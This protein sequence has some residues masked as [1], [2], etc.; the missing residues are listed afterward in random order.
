MV[1]VEAALAIPALLAVTMVLV[2]VV[3][4]ASTSL[5]LGDATRQAA[6]DIARGVPVAD[7]VGAARLRAPGAVVDAVDEG[8]SVRVTA[9][10]EVSAPVWD[11][12]SVTVRDEVVVPREW[13]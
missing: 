2:W 7:A 3:S 12:L 4:L 6:R 11:G 10:V 5:R 13:E 1:I 9:R 8:A